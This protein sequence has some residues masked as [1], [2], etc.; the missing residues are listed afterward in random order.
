MDEDSRF[1]VGPNR[2]LDGACHDKLE[3]LKSGGYSVAANGTCYRK[4]FQGFLPDLM[5]KMY[6]ERRM[7]KKK[8]IECQ[9][10]YEKVEQELR[11]RGVE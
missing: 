2:I 1:G 9:K 3:E 6:E 10:E 4:D 5:G 7:Y 11:K 8:M